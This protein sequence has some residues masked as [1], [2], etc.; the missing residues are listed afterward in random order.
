MV[1]LATTL[2]ASGGALILLPQVFDFF[3]PAAF[4]LLLALGLTLAVA[5]DLPYFIR[6]VV[7]YAYLAIVPHKTQ[8]KQGKQA[9]G[10]A[11]QGACSIFEQLLTAINK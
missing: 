2:V 5:L 11:E 7:H 10:C 8:G 9:D 1:V 3:S 4:Y 6:G